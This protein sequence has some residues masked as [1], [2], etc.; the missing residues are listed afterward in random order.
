MDQK[1][2]GPG[3]LETGLFG[4]EEE[5]AVLQE[6][7]RWASLGSTE[8][9]FI[10]GQAGIG[11][12]MLVYSSF[13][14]SEKGLFVSGKFEQYHS[15]IPYK[16]FIECFRKAIRKTGNSLWESKLSAGMG[17][18]AA[19]LAE[20]IPEL[21][22]LLPAMKPPEPLPPA[23]AQ[24]RFELAICSFLRMFAKREHALVLF[25]DDLQWADQAS[26]R[27]LNT[28]I[29]DPESQYLLAIGAFRSE[30]IR[31][32]QILADKVDIPGVRIR[33]LELQ[34]VEYSGT[35]MITAAV[36]Q[37]VEAGQA[38]PAASVPT[39]LT[40]I[41]HAKSAGNPLFL[42]Q[43]LHSALQTGWIRYS[44]ESSLW[45]WDHVQITS[46]PGFEGQAEYLA[47]KIDRLSPVIRQVLTAAACLGGSFSSDILHRIESLPRVLTEEALDIA[48]REGFIYPLHHQG[49]FQFAHDRI[50]Q[51]A[52]SLLEE[53]RKEQIHLAA[54]RIWRQ[55]LGAEEDRGLFETVYHLNKARGLLQDEERRE[56]STLN[57][58]AAKKALQSSA[59][60][61]ALNYARIGI[62]LDDGQ[63]F[64]HLFHLH[65]IQV[66]CEFLCSHIPAA[67]QHIKQLL[68]MA[69]SWTDRAKVVLVQINQYSSMG[70]YE[71]AIS[72]GLDALAA[73]GIRIPAR[74]NR[75][76]V[77]KEVLLAK[78]AVER[79]WDVL[80]RLTETKD[81]R[82]RWILEL[83]FSLMA[84]AFL[85]YRTVFAMLSSRFIRYALTHGSSY[86]APALYAAF[87]VMLGSVFGDYRSGYRLGKIA[88]RLA[89]QSGVRTIQCKTFMIFGGII[90]PWMLHAKESEGYLERAIQLGIESG[91]YVYVSYAIGAHTNLVYLRGDF[92]E[93]QQVNR[94]HLQTLELT[95]DE[96]IMKNTRVY[97][98]LARRLMS[99]EE[100]VFAVSD[101]RMQEEEFVRQIQEDESGGITMFQYYTYK[102]QLHYWFG[103]FREALHYSELAVPYEEIARHSVHYAERV[104]YESLS[105]T[106]LWHSLSRR[107][108]ARYGIRLAKHMKRLRTWA[109][110]CPANYVHKWYFL[111]AEMCRIRGKDGL[112]IQWIDRA[113]DRAAEDGYIRTRALI[114]EAAARYY[115]QQGSRRI[116]ALYVKEAVA[117]YQ[118]SFM[119][120]KVIDLTQRYP[121][122]IMEQDAEAAATAAAEEPKVPVECELDIAAVIK[123]SYALPEGFDLASLPGKLLGTLKE[124]SGATKAYYFV[125][126]DGDIFL[127]CIAEGDTIQTPASAMDEWIDSPQSIVRYACST[128]ERLAL[129]NAAQ[130]PRFADDPYF[131]LHVCKSVCCLPLLTQEQVVGL[132]VLEHRD[133]ENVFLEHQLDVLELMAAQISFIWKLQHS[134]ARQEPAG[135]Q[136]PQTAEEEWMEPLT[137]RE[138]EVLHWMSVGLTNKEIAERLGVTAGTVKVHCHNIFSK[139]NVTRRT[140]AIVEAKKRNLV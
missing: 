110:Q 7:F 134:F 122:V 123:A 107:E 38:T 119:H 137:E 44:K 94:M 138:L 124:R 91:D 111:Q 117:D 73:V 49:M 62:E 98:E 87:G 8:C 48:A 79:N 101:G 45:E 74:P 116:A 92:R 28:L 139:L 20:V 118:A 23:E 40:Q 95:K 127:E 56:L 11:K 126:R 105:I 85:G 33:E 99:T 84:P 24:A 64:D 36:L 131:L 136:A 72:I 108:K 65:L 19:V 35:Q 140:M 67:E 10:S 120:A 27:L 53:D 17:T 70:K 82:T 39:E 76:T 109:E 63:D 13:L 112:M 15:D 43:L 3:V 66:Q 22:T 2:G 113:M 133:E 60:G 97:A 18:H 37:V 61:T 128:K 96:F 132:V 31:L 30:E 32:E 121:E 93:I 103:R 129:P 106:A 83:M 81:E 80:E 104:F 34:P 86:V 14:R 54:G 88:V 55:Q 26:L 58:A 12:S 25:L 68:Q 5:A 71:E 115:E 125:V 51:A 59:Y 100:D 6:A 89:E 42:K 77:L 9:V 57:L 69:R 114:A 90:A 50:Q 21:R 52:Y 46:L 102:L 1:S 4:R 41:L 16:A 75:L 78:R 29:S 135:D 47:G 130:D